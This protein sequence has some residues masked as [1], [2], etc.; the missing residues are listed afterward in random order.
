MG[1]DVACLDLPVEG[2]IGQEVQQFATRYIVLRVHEIEI[3]MYGVHDDAIGHTDLA[4]LRCIGERGADYLMGAHIDDAV[5]DGIRHRDFAPLA[6]IE[7]EGVAHDTEVAD[8]LLQMAA[9]AHTAITVG[10]QPIDA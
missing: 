6:A 5:G 7:I 1:G 4:D 9:Y 2:T 3:A 8:G 10:F